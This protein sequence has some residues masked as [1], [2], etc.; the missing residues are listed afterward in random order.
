LSRVLIR[1]ANELPDIPDD[2]PCSLPQGHDLRREIVPH[3]RGVIL[4]L[5]LKMVGEEKFGVHPPR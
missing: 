3:P 4:L 5:Q 1:N 2:L